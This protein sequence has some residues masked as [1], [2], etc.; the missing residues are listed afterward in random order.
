ML[1]TKINPCEIEVIRTFKSFS[2]VVIG[3]NCKGIE[4]LVKKYK[5]SVEENWKHTYTL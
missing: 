2:G 5:Q 1:K 4:I 3:T